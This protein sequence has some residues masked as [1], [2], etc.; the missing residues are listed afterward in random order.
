MTPTLVLF[1]GS[2]REQSRSRAALNAAATLAATKGFQTEVLDIRD[3]PLPLYVPYATL[4]DYPAEALP[5]IE[6]FINAFRRAD[7]MIWASPT[8]HGAVSGVFKNAIDFVEFLADDP[9]PYLRE[10]PVGLISANSAIP[11]TS[12]AAMAQELRGWPAPTQ[13]VISRANF[14][15]NLLLTDERTER[16]LNRMID[17]I[18]RFL[19]R[20]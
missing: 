2:L 12:M 9:M 4:N 14:D 11:L 6:K 10:M 5:I 13:L 18:S 7:A 3:V 15:D 17:E 16:K 1:G 8:Y 20:D 19:N